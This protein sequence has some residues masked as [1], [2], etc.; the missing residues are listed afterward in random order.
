[1]NPLPTHSTH[2]V[3]PP[4]GGIDHIDFVKDDNIHML[5]WDD[6]LPELIVLDDG[7]KVGTMGSQTST[8]FSLISNWVLFELT[9]TAPL[10]TARQIPSVPFILWPEDDDLEGRDI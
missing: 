2:V 3:P 1:M 5:S 4:P 6:G 9:S 8:P 10:A 7:Y